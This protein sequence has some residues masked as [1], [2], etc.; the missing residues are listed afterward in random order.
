MKALNEAAALLLREDGFVILSHR[1]PD[2]DSVGSAAALCRGLRALG[3]QAWV[4]DNPE[5]TP[6]CAPFWAGLTRSDVPEDAVLISVDVSSPEMLLRGAEALADRIRLCLDHHP[7]NPGYAALNVIRPDYAAAGELIYE[8]LLTLEAALDPAMGEALYLAVSTDTGG[9]RYANVTAHTFR[10]AAAC[11]E[12]GADVF[13]INRAF[14]TVKSPARV[15]L[16]AHL[17]STAEFF[18]DGKIGICTLSLRDM[19]EASATEDDAD[20]LSSFARSIEGVEIGVLI[21]DLA[22]GSGKLSLRTSEAY[23]AAYLCGLL[24]GGGHKAA[25]GATVP[26]GIEGARAAILDVLARQGLLE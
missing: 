5:L 9:F 21:R 26:G 23:D 17:G 10:V 19:A 3:K 2:G 24:G 8:L 15:R 20:D 12:A 7:S 14:F 11:C 22:D 16:E 4:L 25:A 1:R 6:R 18:M 13:P